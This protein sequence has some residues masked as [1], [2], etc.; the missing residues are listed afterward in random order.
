[1]NTLPSI[2][3]AVDPIAAGRTDI[4]W[5]RVV[6]ADIYRIYRAQGR[7]PR[8]EDRDLAAYV[9]GKKFEDRTIVPGGAYQYLVVA[10][11]GN[12]AV[13]RGAIACVSRPSGLQSFLSGP[14]L[15]IRG[16]TFEAAWDLTRGGELFLIRQYDG[17]A[18]FPV[19][20]IS[21]GTVP[22]LVLKE[23]NG[24]IHRVSDC[25]VAEY[26]FEKKTENEI[27]FSV[28]ADL[29]TCTLG[30]HYSIF[31]EGV[32]F[33]EMRLPDATVENN[34]T[35]GVDSEKNKRTLDN[36]DG[37]LGLSLDR[38]IVAGNTRWGYFPRVTGSLH[39][40]KKPGDRVTD[41]ARMLPIAMVDYRRGRSAGFTNHIE[42]FIEDSPPQGCSTRFGADNKGGMRFEWGFSGQ[43]LRDAFFT[44][45]DMGFFV[46]RWGL[47]LGAART[48]GSRAKAGTL[49]NNL[50]GARIYHAGS[51]QGVP[52]EMRD[53]W[54]FNS[55]PVNM[56][57]S[58]HPGLTSDTDLRRLRREGADTIVYHQSWMR[59]GGS[60]CDPPADYI[61]RN[62]ADLKR[63]V[64]TCHRQ[65][66]RVGLYMRG[67]EKHALF[68]PYFEKFMRKGL[69]GLY[70]DWS[71]PCCHGWQ[72]CS[73]L[74]FSAYTYFLYTRA[75]R[76][77]VG[78][79]GLLI[80][81]S[82]GAPTMLAWAVFDAYLPGE[83]R[84]Q[85]E[86]LGV[87]A[88]E[89]A[90]HGFASCIGTNPLPNVI[91]ARHIAYYAG[92]GFSPHVHLAQFSSHL[93]SPLW[94]MLA[95]V[96]KEAVFFNSMNQAVTAARTGSRAVLVSVYR[97]DRGRLLAIVA[98][99]G[100]KAK[101]TLALDTEL[102]GMTGGYRVTT[103]R[104]AAHGGIR[105]IPGKVVWDGKIT[106]GILDRYEYCGLLFERVAPETPLER[107]KV[108][109]KQL[110]FTI[111]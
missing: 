84:L 106:I 102:L 108:G 101:T 74:H 16:A 61:P 44:C 17:N 103:L 33:C 10:C 71:S 63:F 85:K 29:A 18:W 7:H 58:V 24:K 77:R 3:L 95:P 12:R 65:G 11:R 45:W 40:G 104:A 35:Q 5:E 21:A 27:A 70:V 109:L 22:G 41:P 89:A 86:N 105:K 66:M 56:I 98:N 87:S 19:N 64:D 75:L 30:M 97:M 50:L 62:P 57:R 80:A 39:P 72:G 82:G 51:S 42:F 78:A 92:L 6:G 49:G 69:D 59:S 88:E 14:I 53:T 38:A 25:R 2:D 36:L 91:S 43:S 79:E 107:S 60:N 99:T 67:T 96:S 4:Y 90:Y 76:E 1:M 8:P 110:R 20:D 47:C 13:A 52:K 34:R 15:I 68:Q 94:K 32:L 83:F 46:T 48:R 31:S 73:E 28:S 54:P 100:R 26:K 111:H 55:P 23:K 81:H 93:L 37:Q 9:R